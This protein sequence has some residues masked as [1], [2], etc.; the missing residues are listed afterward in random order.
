MWAH[1]WLSSI[2][3]LTSVPPCLLRSGREQTAAQVLCLVCP[4]Q[5]PHTFKVPGLSGLM[6]CP[7][8]PPRDAGC[9][10]PPG[11]SAKG[12]H[13]WGCSSH[14]L[15]VAVCRRQGCAQYGSRKG[16][17]EDRA[18]RCVVPHAK[19]LQTMFNITGNEVWFTFSCTLQ[20]RSAF[21][22]H[23]REARS[24]PSRELP[25]PASQAEKSSDQHRTQSV[26]ECRQVHCYSFPTVGDEI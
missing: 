4:G 11:W 21:C 19:K 13:K 15:L 3:A 5:W 24:Q 8:S 7:P 20:V 23:W 10:S 26:R 6:L 14:C 22:G 25:E 17:K 1:A 16:P 2:H 12:W 9:H 18:G